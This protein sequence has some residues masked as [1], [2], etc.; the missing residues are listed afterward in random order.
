MSTKG[1]RDTDVLVRDSR[2]MVDYSIHVSPGLKLA[3]P[4]AN[5]GEWDND[6][7]GPLDAILV[8]FTEESDAL[9]GLPETHLIR[10]DAVL[11]EREWTDNHK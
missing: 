10:K 6:E 11:S 8:D 3:L 4:V 9:N 2:S 7:E 5:G 1:R